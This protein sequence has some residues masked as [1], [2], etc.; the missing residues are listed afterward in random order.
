M[1]TMFLTSIN[2]AA[3]RPLEFGFNMSG[4]PLFSTGRMS[5]VGWWLIR[6]FVVAL[7]T[8]SWFIDT[9]K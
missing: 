1:A 8:T 5:I 2:L 4:L 6:R 3:K 7:L 9:V